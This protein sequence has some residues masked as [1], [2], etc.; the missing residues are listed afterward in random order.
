[1][2]DPQ[3]VQGNC[4]EVMSSW[5]A[6]HADLIVADPPYNLGKEYGNG[7]DSLLRDDYLRFTKAWLTQAIR[8]LK[9]TGSLYVFMGFRFIA[10]L[11]LLLDEEFRLQF[12]NWI[13]WYY[14]Q[15]MG[16]TRGF[17]PRHDDILFFTKT[18][19][20][21]FYLDSVRIPQK[22]YRARN[23]MRGANPGDVW[24]FSH[25]HYCQGNRTAHLR[26]SP[27]DCLSGLFWRRR[28]RTILSSIRLL[29]VVLHC[30]SA[31]NL[32]GAQLVSSCLEN[33]CR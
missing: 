13:C 20:F 22:Y 17:S 29:E 27:K 32:T 18:D 12:N 21:N 26:K 10:H 23:N 25:V 16:K 8:I 33:M 7:S 31:N 6:N 5:P 4:I 28:M 1:M 19:Q 30:E 3:I 9:P 11:F 15:G 14:T 24:E 2:I